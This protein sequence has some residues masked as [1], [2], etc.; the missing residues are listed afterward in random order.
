MTDAEVQPTLHELRCTETILEKIK[1]TRNK[2]KDVA[3]LYRQ[4]M[5]AKNCR[6][7]D[8][9]TINRAIIARWSIS[10]L[11]YIKNLARC[12]RTSAKQ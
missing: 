4:L 3:R 7:H 2:R 9:P 5:C 6:E 8:W 10:G 12:G 1:D 11:L